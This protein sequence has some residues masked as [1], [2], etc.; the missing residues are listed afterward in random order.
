MKSICMYVCMYKTHL[1]CPVPTHWVSFALCLTSVRAVMKN[2]ST[3]V[4]LSKS[5]LARSLTWLASLACSWA[6]R[7]RTATSHLERVRRE[8]RGK[9]GRG[10]E[11]GSEEGGG[12]GS[13]KGGERE[14]GE[15]VGR[16]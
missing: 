13:E 3:S 6:L 7:L 15:G 16:G 4:L 11:G 9:G 2:S 14:K 12:G 10:G 8:G 5:C 1:T